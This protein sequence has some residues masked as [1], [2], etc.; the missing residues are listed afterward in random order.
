MSPIKV[1]EARAL[2][3]YRVYL[4]FNDGI[5]KE[6]DISPFLHGPVFEEVKNNPTV[7]E[8]I[9]IEGGTI[10]WSTG[11]DIDPYVLYFGGT[12]EAE[13]YFMKQMANR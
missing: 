4:R 7:F 1:V 3:D 8:D 9:R 10:A 11:A 13:A 12:K 5:E 6:M 2:N